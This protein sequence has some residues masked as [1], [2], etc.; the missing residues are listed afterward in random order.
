MQLEFSDKLELLGGDAAN[1]LACQS[2]AA[3]PNAAVVTHRAHQPLAASELQ[4]RPRDLKPW[5]A[6][7]IRSDGK[8]IPVVK[9]LVVQPRHTSSRGIGC[10][11]R[12]WG[13]AA[14]TISSPN[15]YCYGI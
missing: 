10:P 13:I 6:Y 8:R 5:L 12:Q 9:T 3:N 14:S 1:D 11:H 15:Y 7:A 2:C 4:T